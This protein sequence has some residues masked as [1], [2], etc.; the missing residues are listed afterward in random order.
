MCSRSFGQSPQSWQEAT[1]EKEQRGLRG[2]PLRP[3]L[4]SSSG[5]LAATPQG[6]LLLAHSLHSQEMQPGALGQQLLGFME[7]SQAGP[8][9]CRLQVRSW[10]E[11][12]NGE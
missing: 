1:P 3:S 11:A 2:R 5:Y 10:F 12:H 4:V 6:Q 8:L 9:A 7:G